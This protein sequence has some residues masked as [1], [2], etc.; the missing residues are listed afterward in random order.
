MNPADKLHDIQ[1]LEPVSGWPLAPGWWFVLATVVFI[2]FVLGLYY[3]YRRRQQT[4]WRQLA[5]QQLRALAHLAPREQV[6]Q[7]ALLLRRIAIQRY[8]RLSCAGLS[9]QAWLAWL[10]EHDPRGFNWQQQGAI[11]IAGPYQP[12]DI[13][14]ETQ[15]LQQLSQAIE[16]WIDHST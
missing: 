4:D 7:L 15:Q 13:P 16:A 6:T 14:I 3:Y 5:R 2:G 12:K 10:S 11:L 9:G 8:G 1:G